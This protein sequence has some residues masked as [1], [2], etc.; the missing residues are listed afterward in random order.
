MTLERFSLRMSRILVNY[1]LLLSSGFLPSLP[2]P[3]KPQ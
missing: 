3:N 2:K 1:S